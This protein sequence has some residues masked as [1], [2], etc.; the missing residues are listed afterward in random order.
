MFFLY[1]SFVF[2]F[3]G[4][5]FAHVLSASLLLLSYVFLKEK[6]RVFYS[7]L[8][9]GLAILCDY[10][11]GFISLVWLV[12]IFLNERNIK[13]VLSFVAG[14]MPAATLLIF[15]NMF[16]TGSPLDLLYNHSAEAGFANVENLGFSYPKV[17]ALFG[18]T[19]S[20]YRGLLIYSPFLILCLIVFLKEKG[21]MKISVLNNYLLFIT[22]GYLL[23]ISSHK[24]WWGGWSFGPR[25]LIPVAVLLLY[26]SV[27]YISKRNISKYL[28]WS[29]A[30]FS[31]GFMWL[32][33]TTVV[34][35]V[36]TEIKNPFRDYF[37]QNA[38]NGPTNPN[39]ILTMMF[40]I[41]PVIAAFVW[42]ALF[43]VVITYYFFEHRKK[44]EG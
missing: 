20:P 9:L 30:A 12:Q 3:S 1:G 32:I 21:I 27:M 10:S 33:K 7:G 15:Y 40:G 44:T 23:L 37:L 14:L 28:F 13:S 31:L 43:L 24:V 29:F 6:K 16:T 39:N 25:Q 42:L 22:V 5:F 38:Q 2:V 18:L 41:Q 36:P 35:S 8:F 26:E 34:Y 17:S 19:L 4:T 11:V